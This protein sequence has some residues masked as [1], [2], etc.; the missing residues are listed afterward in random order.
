[1]MSLSKDQQ[2]QK[3]F[4]DIRLTHENKSTIKTKQEDE[5]FQHISKSFSYWTY[6]VTLESVL[7]ISFNLHEFNLS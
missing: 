3:S 1:M 6:F 2:N 7:Y 5:H 4:H